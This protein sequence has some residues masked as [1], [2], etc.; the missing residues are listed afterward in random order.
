M[1]HSRALPPLLQSPDPD[2]AL[3]VFAHSELCEHMVERLG[4]PDAL[5]AATGLPI[6]PYF[7]A[8]KYLWMYENVLEVGAGVGDMDA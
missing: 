5:R 3:T 1:V 2:R 4:G 8:T 7:S 6:S